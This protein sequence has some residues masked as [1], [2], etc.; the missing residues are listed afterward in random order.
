MNLDC[1]TVP[2]LRRVLPG[3]APC[4][5]LALMLFTALAGSV[6]RAQEGMY[7]CVYPDGRIE[8]T[9]RSVGD[10]RNC[11]RLDI[12][13]STTVP[14]PRPAQ[15]PAAAPGAPAP[16]APA[17]SAPSGTPANFPRV[18]GGT[19]RARDT[20]RRR[21]LEDELRQQESRYQEI[22]KEYNGGQPERRGDERNYQRYL[23]RVQKLKDDLERV[24]GD[25][26]S[27]KSELAKLP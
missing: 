22:L 2:R 14:T 26:A 7:K 5:A 24:Q 23:D 6:A 16:R 10:Q 9:N 18:D 1:N 19:Q 11:S 15:A 27:V 20:D 21:I 25:I 13:P 8:Y 12:E 4:A 3:V 17:A